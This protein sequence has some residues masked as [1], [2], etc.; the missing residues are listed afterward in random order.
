MTSYEPRHVPMSQ[1]SVLRAIEFLIVL[2]LV[3]IV[4]G[5]GES[6]S[7]SLV[8]KWRE[9]DGDERVEFFADGSARIQ[10]TSIANLQGTWKILEDGRLQMDF[11]DIVPGVVILSK[12]EFTEDVLTITNEGDGEKT[13]YTR[14][15]SS[16][17]V[18]VDKPDDRLDQ[19]IKAIQSEDF[20]IIFKYG[21]AYQLRLI[22]QQKSRPKAVWDKMAQEFEAKMKDELYREQPSGLAVFRQQG[23][24]ES[25]YHPTKACSQYIVPPHKYE[26][27]ETRDRQV[28]VPTGGLMTGDPITVVSHYVVVSYSDRDTSPLKQQKHLKKTILEF[29]F[30]KITNYLV[31]IKHISDGDEFWPED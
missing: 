11:S 2:T 14:V 26:L 9:V 12:Y 18:S 6:P 4:P 30:E 25:I 27:T 17:T 5:C 10:G 15:S 21:F 13:Y 24:G 19:I 1:S 28:N 23:S 3:L 16:D 8:G 22:G 31:D 20:E 7:E 29:Q